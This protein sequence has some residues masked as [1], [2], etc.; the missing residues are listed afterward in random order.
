MDEKKSW[1]RN[2]LVL[3]KEKV[4]G[5]NINALRQQ[6]DYFTCSPYQEI[7]GAAENAN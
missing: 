7:K 5:G 4:Q 2:R 3:T 1:S 6:S